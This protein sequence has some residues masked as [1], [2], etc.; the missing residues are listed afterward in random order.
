MKYGY[1]RIK[2]VDGKVEN[3][4]LRDPKKIDFAEFFD[5]KDIK[6]IAVPNSVTFVDEY[7]FAYCENL[8]SIKL[9]TGTISNSAFEKCTCL[10]KLVINSEKAVIGKFAFFDCISLTQIKLPKNIIINETAFLCCPIKL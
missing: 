8:T 3:I 2:K 9:P 5:R 10:K 4:R 1:V 7:A 6:G